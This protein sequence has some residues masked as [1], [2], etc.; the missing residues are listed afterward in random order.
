[1]KSYQKLKL[2]S[3]YLE[4]KGSYMIMKEKREKEISKL[5]KKLPQRANK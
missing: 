2:E 1:M 5:I 4:D 3:S